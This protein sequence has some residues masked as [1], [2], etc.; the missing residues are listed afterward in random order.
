MAP[1]F[2]NETLESRRPAWCFILAGM[3]GMT[4]MITT[5]SGCEPATAPVDGGV[6]NVRI[7]DRSFKLELSLSRERRRLGLG[8]RETLA[9]DEGM[10]FVFPRPESQRF[11]MY[12]CLMDIDIAYVDPIG[13]VTAVHTMRKEPPRGPDEE[14]LDYQARL[15]G[16]PSVY[17]AQFVIELAPGMFER[18]GIEA[19]DRIQIDADRL[20]MLGE[21]SEDEF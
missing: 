9:D 15:P 17:P 6:E 7:G 12:D 10:L 2:L 3:I 4:I 16:Y 1:A 11:W 19:G 21:A 20:K 14:E 18:L 13:Y 8:G 5:I